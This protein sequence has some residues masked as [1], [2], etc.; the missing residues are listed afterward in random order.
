MSTTYSGI[1]GE[2][3]DHI[4]EVLNLWI[5]F[6][7]MLWHDLDLRVTRCSQGLD[8]GRNENQGQ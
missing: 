8:R 3:V 7:G 6:F 5:R 2:F 4:I 1:G